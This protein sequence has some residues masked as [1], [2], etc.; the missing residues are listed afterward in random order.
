MMNKMRESIFIAV[1]LVTTL[2][3]GLWFILSNS[4]VFGNHRIFS[5]FDDAMISMVFAR[6]LSEGRGLLYNPEFPRVEGFTNLLWTVWMSIC[7]LAPLPLT[8]ISLLVSVSSLV[9]LSVIMV[10]VAR[11]IQ[12]TSRD[13]SIGLVLVLPLLAGLYELYFWALRGMEVGL[14][15]ALATAVVYQAIRWDKKL[16]T[17]LRN[18]AILVGLGMLARPDFIIIVA[19]VSAGSL[20]FQRPLSDKIKFLMVLWVATLSAQGVHMLFSWVY[21]GSLLPNTYYLKLGG[22]STL[23]RMK[24]GWV[25]FVKHFRRELHWYIFFIVIGLGAAIIRRSW[26]SLRYVMICVALFAIHIFYTIYTGGDAWEDKF[27]LTRYLTIVRD[28]VAR[29]LHQDLIRDLR[30]KY[31]AQVFPES[32]GDVR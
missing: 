22:D 1:G 6:N 30:R 32:L 10:L 16:P 9:C 14:I 13:S 27:I 15:A 19:A 21:Y 26:A 12:M 11:I 25:F 29:K 28:A 20:V 17:G 5:L 8:Q 31:H 4:F 7:H 23:D 2:S 3:Y 24:Y 18:S